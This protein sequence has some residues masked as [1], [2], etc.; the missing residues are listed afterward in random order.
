[1][2]FI[3]QGL[4]FSWFP[5]HATTSSKISRT[6]VFLVSLQQHQVKYHQEQNWDCDQILQMLRYHAI[7]F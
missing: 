4:Q 2:K 7:F 6:A 3:Q 1:M 5:K